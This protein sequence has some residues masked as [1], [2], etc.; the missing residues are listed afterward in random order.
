MLV[1]NQL[2]K[3]QENG[4]S[5]LFTIERW[6][7]HRNSFEVS[8]EQITFYMHADTEKEKDEWIGAI[9][10]AIVRFSKAYTTEDGYDS[11][12]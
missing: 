12:G 11:E 5:I 7:Y 3:R 2:K 1:S 10:R 9:G 6:Q 8:T 4:Y